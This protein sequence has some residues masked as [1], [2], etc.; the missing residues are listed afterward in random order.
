MRFSSNV[1]AGAYARK[2]ILSKDRLIAW[3]HSR[4]F[5]TGLKLVEEIRPRAVLDYGSGDG[6]F[7]ALLHERDFRPE[8]AVGAELLPALRDEC[9]ARFADLDGVQFNLIQELGGEDHREAYDLVVCMEV[10]EHV[11]HLDK[12][13]RQMD[14]ALAPH[15]TIAISVPVEVGLPVLVKQMV[16]RVA[17]WR[18]LG[19]YRSTSSYSA[20]EMMKSVF[21]GT[22]QHIERRV[23]HDPNGTDFYDHK[24][25]NW[26]ALRRQLERYFDVE[27]VVASPVPMLGPLFASQ[28]WL[29]GKKKYISYV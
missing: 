24:G 22:D 7:L 28:V 23:F 21:A 20:L 15:G 25:F 14:F 3:S 4:R 10:L 5:E 6:T 27:R 2:Q 12:I 16:R 29:V 1:A 19:D 17:G 11:I 8:R 26:P 9:S 13:L 18:N